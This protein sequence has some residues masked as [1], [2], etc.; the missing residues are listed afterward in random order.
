M[1]GL[2]MKYFVLKPRGD[3]VYAAAS[4]VAIRAYAGRIYNDNPELSEQLN[5]WA[6]KEAFACVDKEAP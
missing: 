4:R 2:L 1:D 3:D 5:A 6:A